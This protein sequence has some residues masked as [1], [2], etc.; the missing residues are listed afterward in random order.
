MDEINNLLII[1]DEMAPGIYEIDKLFDTIREHHPGFIYKIK[2]NIDIQ[3]KDI[4]SACSILFFRSLS[5]LDY[6]LAKICIN[7]KKNIFMFVDDDFLSL[8]K[9]YGAYNVGT[10][11]GRERSLMRM[12]PFAKAILSSNDLLAEKYAELGGVKRKIRTDTAV[13]AT[14]LYPYK[15]NSIPHRI[16]MYVNDGSTDMFEKYIHPALK[17]ICEF[18]NEKIAIDLFALHPDCS[19]LDEQFE[20]NYIGHMKYPA[21]KKYIGEGNYTIGLAPLDNNGF[22]QYKYFNKYI[23]YTRAGVIGIYSNCPLY[24]QV[25][26]NGVNGILVDNNPLEWAKAIVGILSDEGKRIRC[27]KGAQ[28]TIVKS[29]D[30]HEIAKRIVDS[31]PEL[32]EERAN[33]K[34]VTNLSIIKARIVY[35][36]SRFIERIYILFSC[37][38]KGGL[39]QLF[40][41][42]RLRLSRQWSKS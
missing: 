18:T 9:E 26:E 16:L 40:H 37:Y 14:T 7:S 24:K 35:Y 19:D 15:E 6:Q 31:L 25:V 13:E 22:N 20:V 8:D 11:P 33:G 36:W 39:R 12:L 5:V 2:K 34:K 1:T 21:F 28:E 4:N 38:K 41:A 3:A 42:L 30:R 29:F 17:R 23:E 32:F 27:I 10:W